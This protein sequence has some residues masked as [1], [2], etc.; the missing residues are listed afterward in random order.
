VGSAPADSNPEA[1][2]AAGSHR[3]ARTLSELA[4]GAAAAALLLA[5]APRPAAAQN[6][7]V[8]QDPSGGLHFSDTRY[9]LG[10]QRLQPKSLPSST[11]PFSYSA[12]ATP[13]ASDD[14]GRWDALIRRAARAY[15]LSPA[16]IKAVIHAESSFDPYAVSHRGARGLMQLMPITAGAM[17]V[18]DPFNPWQNIS[19]G[20]RYLQ[21]L[22]QRF[23]GDLNLTLAAYN[24]GPAV[25]ERYNG[26]PPFKVTRRYVKRV[27]EL[28]R[29]YDADFR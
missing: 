26:L 2:A 4:R 22:V 3:I 8:Y 18:S 25:V 15:G 17:G 11:G 14:D 24:A 10:Y 13:D 7:W 9:H 19:G 12:I 6:V 21:Q 20:T 16:M 27:L 5:L 23:D 1:R 28:Y 29:R